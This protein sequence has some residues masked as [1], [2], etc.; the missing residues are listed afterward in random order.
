VHARAQTDKALVPQGIVVNGR[1]FIHA[2]AHRHRAEK[3]ISGRA[4]FAP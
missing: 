3:Q 1:Q 4:G 2:V